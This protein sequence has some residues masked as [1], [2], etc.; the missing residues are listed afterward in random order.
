MAKLD[1]ESFE[2][3]ELSRIYI[4]DRLP[5][6][7]HVEATLSDHGV[8]YAVQVEP[9]YKVVLGVLRIESPGAAFY[10]LSGQAPFA[11]HALLTAGLKAGLVDEEDD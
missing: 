3:K 2:D 10:V 11:R 6:A 8:D 5:E 9:F 4:A 1:I 7:K